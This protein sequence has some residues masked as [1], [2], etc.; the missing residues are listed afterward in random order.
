M[1]WSGLVRKMKQ[2]NISEAKAQLSALIAA[3]E[4]TGEGALIC[5]NGRVVAELVAPRGGDL[6]LGDWAGRYGA[7]VPDLTA[8]DPESLADWGEA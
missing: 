2:V 6:V 5:R 1:V 8:P 4:E 3:L 7:P